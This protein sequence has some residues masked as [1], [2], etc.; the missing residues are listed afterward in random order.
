[1][2]DFEEDSVDSRIL[3]DNVWLSEAK[4]ENPD[5]T[6][7]LQVFDRVIERAIAWDYPHIAAASARGK[8]ILHDVYLHTPDAAH[9]VLQDILSKVGPLPVIEEEQAVVHFH[10]KHYKEAL[11]IYERILPEWHP[12]SEEF[13]IGPLEGYRRAAICAAH[14]GGWEKAA[15]LFKDGAKRA[16][17]VN[18]T[19]EYIGLYADAGFAQFKA[20]NMVDSIKLLHLALQK[21]ERLP[22]DNT[23]ISY[24]T[25]KKRLGSAIG[26]MA[27]QG[28]EN[29]PSDFAEP[30]VGFCSDL[31]TNEEV[32]T[33]SDFPM[34]YSWFFYLAQVE[35]KFGHG[36]TTLEDA[37]QITDGEAYPVLRF[38]L[39][40]LEAQYNFRDR[41][42]NDL[43]QRIH[44]LGEHV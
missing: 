42:F 2:A 14:L 6:R 43:P 10:Q 19:E 38:F 1:M 13:D 39:D 41:T 3:I 33:L 11:N 40:V 9:Q 34:E 25:L 32:L 18:R 37:L 36:T 15:T 4:L 7:C 28:R 17:R 21:F 29:Y 27:S 16:Q 26:W 20:G 22:Q 31:E 5:W 23:N 30:P 24:F 35:H 12:S 8:A 44:Q